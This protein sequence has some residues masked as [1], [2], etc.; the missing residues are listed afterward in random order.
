MRP[1]SCTNFVNKKCSDARPCAFGKEAER[2]LEESREQHVSRGLPHMVSLADERRTVGRDWSDRHPPRGQ[3]SAEGR[4]RADSRP[5]Q[6]G[7]RAN[8][9]PDCPRPRH[10]AVRDHEDRRRSEGRLHHQKGQGRGR[11]DEGAVRLRLQGLEFVRGEARRRGAR[12]DVKTDSPLRSRAGPESP[13]NVA[14]TKYLESLL[15]GRENR[16]NARRGSVAKK[17]AERRNFNELGVNFT[18]DGTRYR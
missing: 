8:R 1:F 5:L 16:R 2:S 15:E 18:N 4:T 6:S 7:Y 3:G 12:I 14:V 9:H 17:M 13:R 10:Q 11:S